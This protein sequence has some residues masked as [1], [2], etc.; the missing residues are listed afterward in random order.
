MITKQDD[1]IRKMIR[2][3]LNK[4]DVRGYDVFYHQTD[5]NGAKEILM[6]GFNTTE[7][8]AS[9]DDLSS[10]GDINIIVYS[11]KPKKPFIMDINQ[12]LYDTK[13]SYEKA[14]ELIVNNYRLYMDLGGEINP[15]TFNK[16][17]EM[18]Y[19]VIIENNGDRC[20]LYPN[21]LK[22]ELG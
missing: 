22:Y 10:Y 14:Q 4:L 9:P 21:T 6:N 2:E 7:V 17:R 15:E 5:E 12:L 13:L 16:L 8:W 11:P 3:K 20:F 19:D 1:F 18:G